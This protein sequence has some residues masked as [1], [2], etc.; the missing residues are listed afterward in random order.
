MGAAAGAVL[1]VLFA[2][3]KGEETRRKISQKSSD[4]AGGV[5]NKFNDLLTAVSDIFSKT[6]MKQ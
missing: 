5:K 2:P 3:D 1:G 4:L 6:K